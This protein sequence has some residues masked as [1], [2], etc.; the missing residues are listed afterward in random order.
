[1]KKVYTHI[2]LN[3]K[4]DLIFH[5]FIFSKTKTNSIFR[6]LK[7]IKP[8]PYL[9]FLLN[10]WLS[11][12]FCS[13]LINRLPNILIFFQ[14]RVSLLTFKLRGHQIDYFFSIK[15]LSLNF[16]IKMLQNKT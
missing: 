9:L 3:N 13:P 14:L 6:I 8:K 2:F 7:K 1:M 16:L 5:G 4:F 10:F 11:V 15:S 12:R